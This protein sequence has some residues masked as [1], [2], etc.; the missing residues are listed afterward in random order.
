MPERASTLYERLAL[1]PD[2]QRVFHK[3]LETTSSSNV[4]Q[5]LANVDFSRTHHVVDVG[6]GNGTALCALASRYPGL[7]ATLVETESVCELARERIARDG[8]T[9]R[10]RALPSDCFRDP[11]PED[12][13][14]FVFMHFLTCRRFRLGRDERPCLW[15]RWQPLP[16][17]PFRRRV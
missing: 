10:V 9:D 16:Y 13:D 8:S 1:R 12:G 11:F 14:C 2:L 5:L 6:G 7:R 3:S 17:G 15:R 4:E